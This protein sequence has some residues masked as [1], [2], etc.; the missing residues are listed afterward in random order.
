MNGQYIDESKLPTVVRLGKA[1]F[2]LSLLGLS[3][4]EDLYEYLTRSFLA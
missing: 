4:G 3:M 1:G 2:L